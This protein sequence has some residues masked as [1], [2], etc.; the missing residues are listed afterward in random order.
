MST[1]PADFDAIVV[2]SGITGGWAA[3]E[4]TERGL[5]VLMLDRGRMVEHGKDYPTEHQAP[6]EQPL[7]GKPIKDLYKNEYPV[8]SKNY[9]FNETTRHF[10]NNDAQYPY[11]NPDA[12]TWFQSGVVGGRSLLWGRQVYRWSDLD[13]EANKSDG[14]GI[15]WPIRYEDIAPWY[16][17]VERFI[18][19]S[20]QAEGLPHL[21][22]SEFLPPMAFN[23]VESHVKTVIADQFRDRIMTIGRAAVLTQ[24]HQGRAA[25]HYCGPCHRGCSAGA[26]FS[27]Q[28][29][30][31]PAARATGNLTLRSNAVVDSIDYD[32]TSGRATGVNVIDSNTFVRRRYTAKLI[33]LCASTIGSTALLLN[34]R[35]EPFPNGLANRSGTLGHYL[36]DHTYRTGA[37]GVFPQFTHTLDRGNRPNGIYIPRFQNIDKQDRDFLRGYNFQGA[38][39]KLPLL[40][41][42]NATT[43]FGAEYKHSL[44]NGPWIMYLMGFGECLPNSNNRLELDHNKKDRY[45]IPQVRF[46][47]EWSENE[48]KIRADIMREAEAMLVAAGAVGVNAF[49]NVG[50]AGE[51]IHEMG[52]ARMG[53]DPTQSVLNRWN[54]SHDVPNLFVT[55]GACM[56]SSSSVNPSLTYMALTARAA[57][58]AAAQ[59]ASGTV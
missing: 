17:K 58:Y 25:C 20:G 2:G 13:F 57:D 32:A 27:T 28:S 11:A 59:L 42:A 26:Y 22:D 23:V 1:A 36:M 38:A 14:H 29:S 55:D 12:F 3:K 6:W 54:Q 45:G 9:L 44:R 4:L 52:T 34:S 40:A 18:G 50:L 37:T 31:L 24:P 15:D 41:Q 30:T 46:H 48:H 35:S 16:S 33:F 5:K 47:F 8:Q 10:F 51:A 53:D 56:T 7:R 43:G 19:V 39:R 49:N 21:P